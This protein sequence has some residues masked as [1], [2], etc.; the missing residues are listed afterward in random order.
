MIKRNIND[1]TLDQECDL[2]TRYLI[3]QS[4]DHYIREKYREAHLY[5]NIYSGREPCYFDY[6]LTDIS[7]N[8]VFHTRIVDTYS[9]ILFR[10]S[11][12]QK[13][14][15]LLMAIL[16]S[17]YPSHLYFDHLSSSDRTIS[18][19][20]ISY[21]MSS[22]IFLFS[23]ALVILGPIHLLYAFYHILSNLTNNT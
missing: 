5:L 2:F 11:I 1:Q 13:K 7:R 23:I 19:I 18:F 6:Y 3:H 4:S 12:V 9:R 14:L 22:F 15:I 20:T 21:N 10:N 16:E 8:S 17:C